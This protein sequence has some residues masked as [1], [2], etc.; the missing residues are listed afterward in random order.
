MI[1]EVSIFVADPWK[2][3]RTPALIA[4]PWPSCDVSRTDAAAMLA[5]AGLD[6][7]RR[8]V[9]SDAIDAGHRLRVVGDLVSVGDLRWA[10]RF[11]FYAS[12]RSDRQRPTA[13]TGSSTA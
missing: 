7:E 6:D 9:V 13:R 2:S 1:G 5:K 3:V 8:D 11:D 10:W 12:E 4:D